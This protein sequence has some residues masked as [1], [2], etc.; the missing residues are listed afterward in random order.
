LAIADY[1]AAIRF[2]LNPEPTLY[3]SRGLVLRKAGRIKAAIK[4]FDR[5]IELAPDNWN[6]YKQ[7]GL[8]KMALKDSLGR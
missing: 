5:A 6:Y 4:D 2:S 8:A 7:R 1:S 3:Y